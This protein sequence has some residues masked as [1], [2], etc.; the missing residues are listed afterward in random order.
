MIIVMPAGHTP[1][2]PGA[3]MLTNTDFRDDFLKDLGLDE[4]SVLMGAGLQ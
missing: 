4:P 3:D 2:R 1:D